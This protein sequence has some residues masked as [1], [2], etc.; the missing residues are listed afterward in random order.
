M[1]EARHRDF[2][3]LGNLLHFHAFSDETNG[4]YTVVEARTAPGAGAPPN[5]HKGEQ[6]SFY[7]LEGEFGFMIDGVETR[8]GPGEMVVVPDGAL[9]AFRCLSDSPGRVL[10]LNAPG[11]MHDRFFS[12]AGEPVPAGTTEFPAP[13][14]VDVGAVMT[15]A[16]AQG[17]TIVPPE[18]APA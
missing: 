9:H 5:H 13:K 7:V 14:P 17:M 16:E 8:H 4:A 12:E 2:H 10:I 18:G 11:L 3:L 15:V 6:E 1:N